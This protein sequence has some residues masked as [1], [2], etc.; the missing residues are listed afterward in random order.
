MARISFTAPVV[1][2]RCAALKNQLNFSR[3]DL[4]AEMACN[5][6]NSLWMVDVLSFIGTEPQRR[7]ADGPQA[8][9]ISRF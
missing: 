6:S 9:F 1:F 3:S 4:G 7:P 2:S 8:N 5:S